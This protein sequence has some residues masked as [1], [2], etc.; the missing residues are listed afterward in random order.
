MVLSGLSTHPGH[1]ASADM[2]FAAYQ[3]VRDVVDGHYFSLARLRHPDIATAFLRMVLETER[4][5]AP[6]SAANRQGYS[7]RR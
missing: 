2:L 3:S 4:V 1:R 5:G 6:A 7:L